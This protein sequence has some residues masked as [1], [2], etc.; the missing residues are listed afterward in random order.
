MAEETEVA[1]P[2]EPV[3]EAVAAPVVELTLTEAIKTVLLKARQHDGLKR[4]LHEYA[5]RAYRLLLLAVHRSLPLL[6]AFTGAQRSWIAAKRAS[7]S[8]RPTATLTRTRSL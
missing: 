6:I 4:G 1:A 2:V 5:L 7:A 3:A 8:S